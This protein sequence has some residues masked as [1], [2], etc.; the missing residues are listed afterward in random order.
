MTEYNGIGD[1]WSETGTEGIVW[2]LVKDTKENDPSWSYTNLVPLKNGDELTVFDKEAPTIVLW[3]GK[4]SFE[5]K[6]HL[7]TNDYDFTGQ[8]IF[9]MWA[10]G[11]Q[12]TKKP[13]TTEAFHLFFFRHY[14]ML[15]RREESK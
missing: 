9:N 2:S 8:A 10:H 13:W 3:Q 6:S 1:A 14:P 7:E 4:L 15:L 12:R 5:K 11:L